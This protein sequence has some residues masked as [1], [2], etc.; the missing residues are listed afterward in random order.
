MMP[1]SVWIVG[2]I[3]RA[4]AGLR[5]AVLAVAA[6]TGL[7]HVEASDAQPPLPP[8]ALVRIGTDDLR[9]RNSISGIA[10][11]PDG[12]LVAAAES[13][14]A[15]PRISLFDVRTG[16]LARLISPPDR[17]RGSVQCVAFSPDGTKLAWGESEGEVAL[18]DLAH[19]RLLFREKLHGKSVNDLAFSPDGQ[20]MASG[21]EDGAVH[22]R[23]V[24]D[25]RD[26]VHDLA[27]G[28]RK[29]VLHRAFGGKPAGGLPVGPPYL[30][31]TPDGAR[32]VVGS[33]SSAT[34]FIW[35]IKDGQLVR[36]IE[37]THGNSRGARSSL[38][39]VAVTPDGRRIVS[40]GEST[41]P[42][43]QTKLTFGPMNVTLTEIRL[44]D[45]ETGERVKDLQGE[46]DVGRGYAALSRDGRHVAVGDF[47]LL[48][49]RDATTGQPE[50]TIALPGSRDNTPAFSP[51][52]TLVAMAIENVLGVFDVR[53]GQRLHHDERTPGG[54]LES[55]AW[56]PSGDRIVTGH[57]DGEVRV[58][59]SATGKLVWHKRL[60]PTL[61]VH[62]R[63][64]VPVFVAFSHEGR[65]IVAAGRRDDPVRY[66]GGIVAIYEAADGTLVREV[67][68]KTIR[69]AALAPDGRMVVVATSFGA[70]NDTQLVGVEVETGRSRWAT[71]SADQRAG[72]AHPAGMQ[73]QPNSSFLEAALTD[74]DVIRFNALTGRE[75]SRF[76]ADGRTLEQKKRF[77]KNPDGYIST[78]AFST[79]GRT[80][81]SSTVGRVDVWDVEAGTLRRRIRRDNANGSI[82][83]LAPNGKLLATADLPHGGYVGEDRIRFHDIDTG[84]Q[85]FALELVDDQAR[86]LAFSPDGT[87]LLAGFQRG[88]AIVWDVRRGQAA[89][90]AKE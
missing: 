40:G 51:D 21:G 78:A 68:Q 53:T 80:L 70:Y 20:T 34:I 26:V 79:D 45:L 6:C 71:A 5:L 52:G 19:D 33:G 22:L 16:R 74:G 49:I 35:R 76:H 83:A 30:A 7:Q 87:R 75:Q 12:R 69:W 14:Y 86:V 67:E 63:N 84:E 50:R 59:E 25:P 43:T 13:Y 90:K 58:W 23:R 44:L 61:G 46:E 65:H 38:G 77:V 11:S 66:E 54:S 29:P 73:F 60:A 18:W 15:V 2:K 27:T 47:G 55:A 9:T 28:E 10:F 88:S 37:N 39:S 82:L 56:S 62:G 57:D 32:L 64:P 89:S 41:V 48:R 81:V 1:I 4:S 72:F 36:R 3:L 8:R 17:V 31:F 85:V 42:I 24:E